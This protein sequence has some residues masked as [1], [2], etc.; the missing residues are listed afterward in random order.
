MPRWKQY[1]R[2]ARTDLAGNGFMRDVI[3]SKADA[4]VAS[5][6]DNASLIAYAKGILTTD[7]D[8]VNREWYVDSDVTTSGVGKSWESAFKTVTEAVTAADEA[9]DT[10]YI[11]K[12]VYTEAAVMNI[13][14]EGLRFIGASGSGDL[15]GTSGIKASASH[16]IFT[17]NAN[18]VE[19]HDLAFIQNTANPIIDVATTVSTYKTHIKGCFFSG[20]AQT[21]GVRGGLAGASDSVDVVVEESSFYQ[22]IVGVNLNGTRCTIRDNMFLLSASDTAIEVPMSGGNRPELRIIDNI[23]RG[24]DSSDVGIYFSATPT[25]ELFTMVGNH[26]TNCATPVTVEKNTSWYEGNYWGVNNHLYQPEGNGRGGKIV[27]VDSTVSAS[28]DGLCEKAACNT[29]TLGVAKLVDNDTLNII[30][31]ET[32]AN[33]TDFTEDVIITAAQNGIHLRGVGNQAEAVLWTTAAQDGTILTINGSNALV[34]NIRF[35]PNGATGRAI[36]LAK[37]G[38][39]AENAAGAIIQNCTFRATT[40]DG[41]G[42][43][44]EGANDVTIQDCTFKGITICLGRVDSPNCLPYRTIFRR[45]TVLASCTNGVVGDFRESQFYDNIFQ[46]PQL[47]TVISTRASADVAAKENYVEMH[48]EYENQC[49]LTSTD[50]VKCTPLNTWGDAWCEMHGAEGAKFFV[51]TNIVGGTTGQIGYSA[52]DD[53]A[54]GRS[55]ANAFDTIAE[56]VTAVTA[57]YALANTRPWARRCTVFVTGDEIPEAITAL[58]T[59]GVDWVGVGTDLSGKPRITRTWTIATGGTRNRF[60]NFEFNAHSAAATVSFAAGA[61]GLEFHDCDFRFSTQAIGATHG[62]SITAG[63]DHLLVKNC[64][65]LANGDTIRFQTAAFAI[66]GAAAVSR[67]LFEDCYIEGKVGVFVNANILGVGS[68]VFR[69]CDIK[70]STLCVDENRG[71]SMFFGCNLMSDAVCGGAAAPNCIDHAN[72]LSMMS[73]C[74]LSTSDSNGP[75][76]NLDASA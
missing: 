60:Y 64:R 61:H 19:F 55:W 44:S 14:V 40:E 41:P 4:P 54:Y 28:G 53:P 25:E 23:I 68:M 27:W 11:K 31:T 21:F 36:F 43:V 76:P 72:Y 65:F 75:F 34:E 30:G 37:S 39:L 52:E 63:I 26:V 74:S 62:L 5:P 59:R 2:R 3:G 51:D 70:A 1:M 6:T 69:N 58:P 73:G 10:I 47:T 13:T 12:G 22:C 49:W 50:V 46:Y 32:I 15:W 20:S 8:A 16:T 33:T 66:A 18:E 56:A 71:H 45:N 57:W 38:D 29:I 35:R 7:G 17:V 9:H 42:I 24:A 48:Q 67:I